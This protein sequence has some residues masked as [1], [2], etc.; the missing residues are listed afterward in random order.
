M[1]EKFF[2]D[3]RWYKTPCK[4]VLTADTFT[5]MFCTCKHIIIANVSDKCYF[6]SIDNISLSHIKCDF[7][8]SRNYT[9]PKEFL[10]KIYDTLDSFIST[11]LTFLSK[12]LGVKRPIR[13]NTDEIL[14]I[15]FEEVIAIDRETA[16]SDTESGQFVY[17]VVIHNFYGNDTYTVRADSLESAENKALKRFETENDEEEYD[18]IDSIRIYKANSDEL[19]K[20][21]IFEPTETEP[22]PEAET[23]KPVEIIFDDENL[24]TEIRTKFY[25][26]ESFFVVNINHYYVELMTDKKIGDFYLYLKFDE[27]GNEEKAMCKIFH[28]NAKYRDY[29]FEKRFLYALAEK[30]N[31]VYC[32]P[33]YDD[34]AFYTKIAEECK[35]PET[36]EPFIASGEKCF[37]ISPEK[38]KQKTEINNMKAAI[39]SIYGMTANTTPET[40]NKYDETEDFLAVEQFERLTG[41]LFKSLFKA[42]GL[43]ETRRI[44]I[45]I[46]NNMV[47]FNYNGTQYKYNPA[48]C[49]VYKKEGRKYQRINWKD[50]TDDNSLADQRQARGRSPP[51]T[52]DIRSTAIQ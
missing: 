40:S 42:I 27:N 51:F 19:L 11:T 30:Y 3:G 20:E 7:H 17:D 36:F 28:L 41:T 5:V 46:S 26:L 8:F 33:D 48:Q 44:P 10:S 38:T 31:G 35:T 34:F 13:K 25:L 4:T 6:V 21:I 18:S 45:I 23:T 24:K 15:L 12:L 16:D 9:K 1:N 50:F 49:K 22:E 14:D 39:N 2:V 29:A 32:T 43:E 52:P 47:Y 37:F